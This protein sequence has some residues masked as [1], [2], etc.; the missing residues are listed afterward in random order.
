MRENRALILFNVQDE[1]EKRRI[2]RI[3]KNGTPLALHECVVVARRLIQSGLAVAIFASSAGLGCSSSTPAPM[4]SI[5]AISEPSWNR[6]ADRHRAIVALSRLRPYYNGAVWIDVVGDSR[7]S[8]SSWRDGRIYISSHLVEIL[9]DDELCAVVAHEMGHL[10]HDQKCRRQAIFALGGHDGMQEEEG[11]DAT[12][13]ILLRNAGIAP[14]A[15][16]RV[17]TKLISSPESDIRLRERLQCRVRLIRLSNQS[18]P[19]AASF[20]TGRNAEGW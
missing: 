2:L 7:L 15:L 4:Q 8:A 13:V 18:G 3:C 12:G 9:D 6:T 10:T 11:A 20:R 5:T 17:L 19:K 16:V 1:D 14:G